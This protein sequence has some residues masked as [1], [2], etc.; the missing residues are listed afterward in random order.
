[1]SA[2]VEMVSGTKDSYPAPF[3]VRW[4]EYPGEAAEIQS[5]QTRLLYLARVEPEGNKNDEAAPQHLSLKEQA[6]WL[7]QAWKPGRFHLMTPTRSVTVYLDCT[8]GLWGGSLG[9]QRYHRW[10]RVRLHLRSNDGV[11]D[12]ARTVRIGLN[13]NDTL[14]VDISTG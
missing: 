7:M 4:H 13:K 1:M 5:G 6:K 3:P 12:Q 11:V 10:L 2:Q 9:P 8:A 14:R